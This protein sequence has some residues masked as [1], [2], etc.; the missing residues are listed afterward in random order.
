[1]VQPLM[2]KLQVLCLK[3]PTPSRAVGQRLRL[4]PPPLRPATLHSTYEAQVPFALSVTK[5]VI[6]DA[7]AK[8]SLALLPGVFRLG[9]CAAVLL[10]AM[11]RPAAAIVWLQ[12]ATK[13]RGHCCSHSQQC[14]CC[15]GHRQKPRVR[16][17]ESGG[18]GLSV[19]P[20]SGLSVALMRIRNCGCAV[21]IGSLRHP[22]NDCG[23]VA[24]VCCFAAGRDSF[25]R[26][27]L[28]NGSV[29][30]WIGPF[31]ESWRGAAAG[32]CHDPFH[33]HD[34]DHGPCPSLCP[35]PSQFSFA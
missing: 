6:G 35:C 16:G 14:G 24:V 13:H 30:E 7:V 10:R 8:F 34:H 28:P 3:G 20:F 23:F 32:P 11:A 18:R 21:L 17:S 31:R 27:G 33:A 12:V 9:S 26:R 19:P 5:M 15:C 29:T 1:M 2:A 25:L 4:L 22:L